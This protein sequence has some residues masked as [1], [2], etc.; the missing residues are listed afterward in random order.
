MATFT[1]DDIRDEFLSNGR[2]CDQRTETEQYLALIRKYRL[3]TSFR[4]ACMN[5]F[6]T[7]NYTTLSE[8][9]WQALARDYRHT[10][11]QAIVRGVR[12]PAPP[13]TPRPGDRTMEDPSA[14]QRIG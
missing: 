12:P 11:Q 7:P 14:R 2:L 3:E 10:L 13:R 4:I 1:L 8:R 5:M 6:R 9:Q